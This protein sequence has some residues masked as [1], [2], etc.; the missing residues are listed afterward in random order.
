[1]MS[2]ESVETPWWESNLR[3]ATQTDIGMRRTNNQD[4]HI[5]IPAAS[6]TS[7][8]T[9]GHLFIVADGM[10]AHA[11]GEFASQLAVETISQSYLKQT[12]ESP[13]DSI[14]A[15]L[16]DAH[17]LI[18]KRGSDEEAFHGMG[19]TADALL[20]LPEGAVIGHVGDSRVYRLRQKLFEQLTFDHSVLWEVTHSPRLEQAFAHGA[21]PKNVITRSLGPTES[22][23]VDIE[24]PLPIQPGDSFL[25]CSDGLSGQVTD[26]E[27]G[28]IVHL[29]PPKEAVETLINLAN[30]R[31]GPDNITVIVVNVLAL[32]E[33]DEA[34]RAKAL[35]QKRPPLS[36]TTLG[37]MASAAALWTLVPALLLMG[38]LSR[39]CLWGMAFLAVL[40]TLA[41]FYVGRK[42]LFFRLNQAP[43]T[44]SGGKGPYV[45]T[46]VKPTRI[47]LDELIGK[48]NEYAKILLQQTPSPETVK[49][50]L[51]TMGFSLSQSLDAGKLAEAI[52][53]ALKRINYLIRETKKLT[54]KE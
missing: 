32:P 15:A 39:L 35:R 29:F 17:A 43:Q 18:K 48:G 31:G 26:Q 9:R 6:N 10:G 13:I 14:R 37:L 45:H 44:L 50:I 8:Q 23:V 2:S 40:V 20:L 41:A 7:W 5:A 30:L 1:M 33:A 25:L 53:T 46:P 28:L 27:M 49:N 38:S 3:Y 52:H 19:T 21:I 36:H 42:T 16:L 34:I 12:S 11:A 22:L 4:S 54:R 24:G 51:Q 47:F